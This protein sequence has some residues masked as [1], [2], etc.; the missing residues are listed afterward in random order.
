MG[1]NGKGYAFMP[2]SVIIRSTDDGTI[3]PRTL[4]PTQANDWRP[5]VRSSPDENAPRYGNPKA[6][7][8][9]QGTLNRPLM[10]IVSGMVSL[11]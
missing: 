10:F 5:V 3:Q 1:Q 8:N 7:G 11:P 4:A 6:F 2:F 9:D